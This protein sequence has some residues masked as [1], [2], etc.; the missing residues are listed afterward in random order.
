M[1]QINSSLRFEYLHGDLMDTSNPGRAVVDL[2]RV[3]LA[4]GDQI[5][6]SFEFCSLGVRSYKHRSDSRQADGSKVLHGVVAYRFKRVGRDGELAN[7]R[8][9]QGISVRS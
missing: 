4:L 6:D 5:L 7:I 9:Q 2:S 3:L 1:R 8:D